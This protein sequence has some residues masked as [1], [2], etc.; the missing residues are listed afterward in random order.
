MI[1]E[2]MEKIVEETKELIEKVKNS[3]SDPKAA[4]GLKARERLIYLGEHRH[5][6]RSQL[7]ALATEQKGLPHRKTSDAGPSAP[8]DKGNKKSA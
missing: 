6:L 5:T 1:R 3:T 7:Q 2:E 4:D 8:R